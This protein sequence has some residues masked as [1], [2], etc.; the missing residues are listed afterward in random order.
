MSEATVV[1]TARKLLKAK[2]LN[3]F[4]IFGILGNL[5]KE[6][7]LIANNLQDS[8]NIKLKMTDATYTSK[9]DAG[10]YKNFASDGAGYGLCQWTSSDRKA[11]LL[12][13]AQKCGVSIANEE[14]QINYMIVELTGSYYTSLMTTLKN[15]S[16][17]KVA[18]DAFLTIFERPANADS[19]KTERAAAGEELYKKYVTAATTTS[20]VT[21]TTTNSGFT[22]RL[23]APSS[24][25]KYWIHTSKGGLN[26][27]ILI[28]GSSCLPNC[29]GYAWGRFYEIIGKR[30]TLSR[31][32]AEM[33]FGT[34]SDGYKRSA[35]PALGAIAC[36][37]KGKVG[38][39][40]DGAGHVAVVEK[41]A[42]NG[43]I[44]TS[45]S[46]Y[47]GTTFYTKTLTKASGYAMNGYTFQ[48]FIL[49]PDTTGTTSTASTSDG[50]VNYK[51]KVTISNL[52]IRSTPGNTGTVKGFLTPGVYTIVAESSGTGA[53]KWG[54]LKSGAGWISL[55]YATKV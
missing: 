29:V 48:G 20:T 26:E 28:K 11:G 38:V 36:W 8:Y 53:S 50:T 25:D 10:T 19:K 46:A 40:S 43:D 14:M 16:S 54:K 22:P 35:T 30:P 5:K 39:S 52:R 6:S 41:I 24:T 31:A 2:G 4:A 33:W 27:C 12:A 45:N 49:P 55:D 7:G 15:A 9:V 13:Y 1:S 42:S 21:A 23:S 32:N 3:D 47:S 17:V 51:V 44:T 18:S 37:S 34:T